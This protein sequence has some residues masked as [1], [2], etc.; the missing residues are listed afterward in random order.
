[1]SKEAFR[2]RLRGAPAERERKR[3][4]VKAK[5]TARREA[6]KQALIKLNLPM[7]KK[8]AREFGLREKA[9]VFAEELGVLPDQIKEFIE[10]REDRGAIEEMFFGYRVELARRTG[11]EV[12]YVDM[13]WLDDGRE[14]PG[15]YEYARPYLSPRPRETLIDTLELH[16][17]LS[18]A[19]ILSEKHDPKKE[20][21]VEIGIL[22]KQWKLLLPDF[23]GEGVY[24]SEWY[25]K[26]SF[27][28]YSGKE[29]GEAIAEDDLIEC[30]ERIKSAA[31]RERATK[32]ATAK[33]QGAYLFFLLLIELTEKTKL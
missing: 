20:R 6:E 2:Q 14:G 15:W 33:A 9:E 32:E 7:L 19:G 5:V 13:V 11:R 3:K 21:F 23:F 29:G 31:G 17:S 30:F 18:G 27:L 24:E 12:G 22:S 25:R 26:E 1:M 8:A 4:E 28:N 16:T 10:F